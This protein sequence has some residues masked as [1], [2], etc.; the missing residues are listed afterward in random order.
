VHYASRLG[1]GQATPESPGHAS[2]SAA[3]GFEAGRTLLLLEELGCQEN[4]PQRQLAE[5][6]GVAVSL[7]NRLIA[8]LIKAGHIEIVDPSVKP[9]AYRLSQAGQQYRR[10]L[11]HARL[12]SVVSMFREVEERIRSRLHRLKDEGIRRVAFYGVGELTEVT[13]SL[14]LTL[15]FDVVGVVDDDPESHGELNTGFVVGSPA[16]IKQARPDAVVITTGSR[17]EDVERSLGVDADWSLR[18]LEL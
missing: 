5:R 1:F 8:Q 15:D 10:Q 18:F 3:A 16:L 14:A 12:Y 9:F 6:L 13:Y 7:V 4:V 2:S 11:K 17:P